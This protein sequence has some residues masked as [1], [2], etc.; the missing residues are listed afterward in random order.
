RANYLMSP[1]LVIAYAL[2]GR[3]DVDLYNEPLGVDAEGRSVFLKDIWPSQQE[4]QEAIRS[5]VKAEPF[6]EEYAA[7]FDGDE[8]WRALPVPAGDLD[9]WDE[10]STYV[11][12]PPY[13]EGMPDEPPAV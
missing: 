10:E 3:M 13:F 4:V 6:E 9:A 2:A 12:R 8:R 5:H 7:I 11:K 1:P